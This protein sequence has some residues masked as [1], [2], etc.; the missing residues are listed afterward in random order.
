VSS[1]PP[2]TGT[3]PTFTLAGPEPVI[4][5]VNTARGW[6]GGE[7]QVLW[8]TERLHG[9]GVRSIVAARPGEP[10]AARV[11]ERGLP[12]EP[13]APGGEWD[14]RAVLRL[15]CIARRLGANILNAHDGHANTLAALAVGVAGTLVITRRVH[16]R[17]HRNPVSRWKFRR[18]D[19]VI[20]IS[21]SVRGILI[22]CG[23]PASRI[24]LVRSG[25]PL[26]RPA[27]AASS[28][29]LTGLGVTCGVPLVVKVG[30]LVDHKDPINFVRAM[31]FVHAQIPGVQALIVGD[32]PLRTR[33]ASEIGALGLDGVVHLAGYRTDA[34]ALLAAA[35]VAVLSSKDEGLGTV[36]LDAMQLGVPVVATAIAP[37]REMIRGGVDGLLVP[38]GASTALGAA[39]AQALTDPETSRRVESA[40]LRLPEFSADRTAADTLAVYRAVIRGLAAPGSP[41]A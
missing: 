23:V 2:V 9:M 10:L 1:P 38:A 17:V 4:L 3:D 19:A 12:F 22:D 30:A 39:I 29:T 8:L 25:V 26:D 7:R 21:T 35:S 41:R 28:D 31:K 40:R 6:R 33:V 24:H 27:R 37:I 11:L 32:G 20:A 13:F 14:L 5:H 18:A 15:R 36:I 34:D 16:H